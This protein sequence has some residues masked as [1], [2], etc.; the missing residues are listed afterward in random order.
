[1]SIIFTRPSIDTCESTDLRNAE[2]GCFG[3]L[4]R[5]VLVLNGPNRPKRPE[6]GPYQVHRSRCGDRYGLSEA[7]PHHTSHPRAHLRPL[8]KTLFL[9]FCPIWGLDLGVATTMSNVSDRR[10]G[11]YIHVYVPACAGSVRRGGRAAGRTTPTGARSRRCAAARTAELETCVYTRAHCEC[12]SIC[13]I[14]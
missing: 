2:G 14:V 9:P 3:G 13:A 10:T 11:T 6:N 4:K 8:L 5:K 1:M 7:L 12:L